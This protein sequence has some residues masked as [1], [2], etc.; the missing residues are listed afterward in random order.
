MNEV[1][2]EGQAVLV[3]D[4]TK[5]YGRVRVIDKLDLIVRWNEVV[6]LLGPN[7]SGKT[8]LLKMLATL[9]R[10]DQGTIRLGGHGLGHDAARL[11]RLIGVVTHDPMLYGD[12]T[13][14]ENLRFHARLFGLDDIERRIAHV[15]D[16]VGI[17]AN[18]RQKTGTLSHGMQ[19]R[20]SIARALLHDP[21]ILLL[22]EPET[23]LDQNALVML[24]RLVKEWS[25]QGRAVLMATHNLDRALAIGSRVV[26]LARG[27]V[28]YEQ[29]LE[30]VGPD[31][32]RNAYFE[33][34]GERL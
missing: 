25:G 7:G 16:S 27:T 21:P 24:E 28:A 13:G 17:T 20:L 12:L 2:S 32:V 23:G 11:R 4:L 10:A 6:V 18:L 31:V 30:K 8:T 34:T 5:S 15:A 26:I 14:D 9:T 33:H 3:R 29:S 1:I 22:D 19:K